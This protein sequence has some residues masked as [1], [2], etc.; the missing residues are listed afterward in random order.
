ML[1][2]GRY[3]GTI[4]EWDYMIEGDKVI[5][6]HGPAAERITVPVSARWN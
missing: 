3:V 5:V 1:T 2:P 6:R 4:G